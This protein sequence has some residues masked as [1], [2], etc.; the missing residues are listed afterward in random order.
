M[1]NERAAELPPREELLRL[2]GHALDEYHFVVRLGWQRTQ[3]TLLFNAGVLSAGLGLLQLRVPGVAGKLVALVFLVGILGC[4]L[5]IQLVRTGHDYYRRA[6]AQ[7]T[8]LEHALGFLEGRVVGAVKVSLV[9]QVTAGQRQ[10]DRILRDPA[11]WLDRGLRPWTVTWTVQW[12]LG[13][14]AV[15]NGVAL[16]VSLAA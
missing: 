3:Q 14:L 13:G 6:V 5:G 10:V 1:P 16:A 4:A 11:G 9:P 2:Y 12:L 8:A 15:A 7:K